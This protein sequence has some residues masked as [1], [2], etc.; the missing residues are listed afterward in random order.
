[1][2]SVI[3]PA[4][5]AALSPTACAAHQDMIIEIQKDGSFIGLPKEFVPASIQIKFSNS[6]SDPPI[7]S[8]IITLSGHKIKIPATLLSMLKCQS[9]DG[10]F[11]SASWYHDE[12]LLPYYM[13]IEF[14]E[15]G[16]DSTRPD[17]PG[18]AMFLNL[19]TGMLMEIRSIVITKPGKSWEE[20]VINL[21]SLCSPDELKEFYVPLRVKRRPN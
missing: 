19:R 8:L 18:I 1:M 16:F 2:K 20:R 12:K 17:N 14:L 15:P 6:L 13:R 11:A 21:E 7:E 3:M 9:I 4:L 10:V 5:L